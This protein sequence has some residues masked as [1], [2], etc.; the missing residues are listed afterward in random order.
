MLAADTAANED[1]AAG[2]VADG[3]DGASFGFPLP[4]IEPQLQKASF[5]RRPT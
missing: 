2:A 4:P 1:G 3:G 5:P